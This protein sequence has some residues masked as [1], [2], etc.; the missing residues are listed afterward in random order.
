MPDRVNRTNLDFSAPKTRQPSTQD[1]RTISHI[2][3]TLLKIS[4]IS[5]AI[6]VNISRCSKSN[7][8]F[9]MTNW[10]RTCLSSWEQQLHEFIQNMQRIQRL[11]KYRKPQT[12]ECSELQSEQE[13]Y[14]A[15]L[16]SLPQ[17]VRTLKPGLVCAVE[18][19]SDSFN[20][21]KRRTT[22]KLHNN[23]SCAFSAQNAYSQS[24][25]LRFK[26]LFTCSR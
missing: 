8:C 20:A 9:F 24:K 11:P 17:V 18:N 7:L 21:A 4:F 2:S 16:I 23:F 12:E 3:E 10:H 25:G 22:A 14:A 6:F 1:K 19:F 15:Y 26:Y 5:L 13:I